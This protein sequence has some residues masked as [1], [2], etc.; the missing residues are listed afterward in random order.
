MAAERDPW[1]YISWP[2]RNGSMTFSVAMTAPIA[3]W[4]EERPFGRT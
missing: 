3:A 2:S 4:A 1:L